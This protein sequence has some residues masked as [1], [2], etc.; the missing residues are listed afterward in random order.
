MVSGGAV[1][2]LGR[3]VGVKRPQP[4]PQNQQSMP[5]VPL[6]SVYGAALL[7]ATA[8]ILTAKKSQNKSFEILGKILVYLLGPQVVFDAALGWFGR[9]STE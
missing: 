6:Y 2:G 9:E 4:H 5:C 8:H 1:V 3:G 7:S